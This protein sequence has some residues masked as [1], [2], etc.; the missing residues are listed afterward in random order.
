M[1]HT[2]SILC[3]S[4]F[5]MAQDPAARTAEALLRCDAAAAAAAAGSADAPALR[6]RLQAALVAP[7][8]RPAA[9][10]AV[11]AQFPDSD[12]ADAAIL[13]G[14][15]AV[16][17][18]RDRG[19][20][21]PELMAWLRQEDAEQWSWYDP[22]HEEDS[23]QLAPLV[24]G[25][26]RAL[27]ARTARAGDNAT[28]QRARALLQRCRLS[29]FGFVPARVLPQA[30]WAL[31][32]L[33]EALQLRAWRR[34]PGLGDWGEA[35]PVRPA[36]VQLQL[37]PTQTSMPGLGAGDWLL[38]LAASESPWRALRTVEV[39]DLDVVALCDGSTLALGAWQQGEPVR[40]CNWQ[41]R[42]GARAMGTGVLGDGAGVCFPTP[43]VDKAPCELLAQVAGSSAWVQ[44][45]DGARWNKWQ[46]ADEG[47]EDSYE[48]HLMLDRS[49]YRPGQ[50]LQGRV[51]VRR[52]HFEGKG[53]DLVVSTGPA[54]DMPITV[55]PFA[56]EEVPP[57]MGRTD[58]H[59]VCAFELL[60]P[61][62]GIGLGTAAFAI[63]V[64][65][66]QVTYDYDACTIANYRR[67]AL[68]VDVTG[69]EEVEQGAGDPQF[70]VQVR[71]ASGAP[72]ADVPVEVVAGLG[73]WD[74]YPSGEYRENGDGS[75]SITV[76]APWRDPE[77]G[78]ELHALR[79]DRD[80]KVVV[81]VK[82][83]NLT[84]NW[85]HLHIGVE[86][87]DGR[88]EQFLR[89]LY[90][91][92][93]APPA[94]VEPERPRL[95]VAGPEL[96][97]VGQA[98][99]VQVSGEAGAHVLFVAGRGHGARTQ[100]LQLDGKG[101]AFVEVTPTRAEWPWLDL[102]VATLHDWYPTRVPMQL[103]AAM[104]P[105]VELPA[106]VRPGEL[107]ACR[108]AT[109]APGTIVTVAVVDER[110]FAMVPD[111]TPEPN[112]ALRPRAPWP[113][114]THL[115]SGFA[116]TPKELLG[117]MLEHGRV[118]PAG[119]RNSLDPPA[120]GFAA[121]GSAGPPG[122]DEVREDFR[123]TAAFATVIAGA[124]G[125]ATV[126][127][128]L[129]DD[130]TTW[131]VRIVGVAPDGTSF[132]LRRDM[133]TRLPLAAEP[134]LPRVLRVGDQVA[135]PVAI[136]RAAVSV[137][138]GVSVQLTAASD[139]MGLAVAPAT[140]PCTVAPGSAGQAQ[141]TLQAVAA[142]EAKLSLGV[143]LGELRD[144]SRRAIVVQP[145][146][147]GRAMTAA[148]M[149]QAKV[150]VPTP[151]GVDPARELEVT[152]LG[153]SA[154][155]WRAIAD[156]LEAYPYGCAE[157]TLSRLLPYFA[158]VRGRKAHGRPL[159]QQDPAFERRLDQGM[160]RLRG[161]QHGRGGGFAFW[162]HGEVDLGITVLVLHGLCCV[163][164]GGLDPAQFGLVADVTAAP[165]AAAL[166]RLR[167]RHGVLADAG[168]AMA[169]ELLAACLRLQPDCAAA[170]EA[171]QAGIDGGSPLSPGLLAR[172]GLALLA[173]GD[174]RRAQLCR[175]RSRDAGMTNTT[176]RLAPDS[177]PGDDPLAVT[178]QQLELAS[179]LHGD[180]ESLAKEAG[181]V[182][183][184]SLRDGGSTFAMGCALSALALALPVE[185]ASVDTSF[186]ATVHSGAIE[187]AVTLDAEHGFTARMRVP[188]AAVCSATGPDDRQLLLVV[189]GER[190]ERASDHASWR[191]PLAV[192]R[193]L[194]RRD[195]DAT[196]EQRKRGE[197]LRP[198]AADE[199]HRNELLWL[200]VRVHSPVPAR[201]VVVDC[202]LP[203]GFELPIEPAFVERFDDRV[204]FTVDRLTGDASWAVPVLA[205]IT[206]TMVWPPAT[207]APMY[208]TGCEG[209]TA[210]AVL[211]VRAQVAAPA[212][213]STAILFAVPPPPK[214]VV[215]ETV[216]ERADAASDVVRDACQADDPAAHR[217]AVD[218]AFAALSQ[219]ARPADGED[220]LGVLDSL[221]CDLREDQEALTGAP[222]AEPIDGW[223]H[224]AATLQR[225][226]VWDV[227]ADL[228]D[229][230]ARQSGRDVVRPEPPDAAAPSDATA[231]QQAIADVIEAAS[232]AAADWPEAEARE[233]AQ[234]A[235]AHQ[236][237]ARGMLWP[238]ALLDGIQA[239][240]TTAALR[241]ELLLA[242]GATQD[243]W[244]HC[245]LE[246]MP[247]S[248]VAE[249]PPTLLAHQQDEVWSDVVVEALLGSAS[250]RVE[251]RRC[252]QQKETLYDQSGTLVS[253][254]PDELWAAVPLA[255]YAEFPWGNLDDDDDD[256]AAL[257]ATCQRHLA[258]S[259]IAT[260]ALQQE[261]ADDA[262]LDW[263]LFLAQVLRL[264][265][266]RDLG[267]VKIDDEPP[268]VWWARALAAAA[269]DVA[270]AAQFAAEARHS[271]VVRAA[272]GRRGV[273]T[274][275]RLVMPQ[276]AAHGSVA[277]LLPVAGYLNE[278]ECRAVYARL[279][280][281][282]VRALLAG[283]EDDLSLL[284]RAHDTDD[285]AALW[286][287]GVRCGEL[288]WVIDALA[289]TGAGLQ[290]LKAKLDGGL[291]GGLDGRDADRAREAYAEAMG[292]DAETLK[293]R[294]DAP[295]L[296]LLR[297][298]ARDGLAGAA[299]EDQR[300]QLDELR[301]LRGVR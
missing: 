155:A 89:R 165:F 204:A 48:A 240:A 51:L 119:Y 71:W 1:L 224:R 140:Q 243:R 195:P 63:E 300:R 271:P 209:G 15:A 228:R 248:D 283:T 227:I 138:G 191:A 122:V 272:Y 301:L 44:P 112:A 159:P 242:A 259:P 47:R 282:S 265:G 277:Q 278:I 201:Y 149:G 147:V 144:R 251:L 223:T 260:D 285:A 54:A 192:E 234:A 72:A 108:V 115:A 193:D 286:N 284:Q 175:D 299:T 157:Q 169:M 117:A 106:Q 141:V 111:T 104:T 55:K 200:R 181:V 42:S 118:P 275:L 134:L 258:Q 130:L 124:D 133:V 298:V 8:Q 255:A 177:F 22:T 3:L 139:A 11:A 39:S 179:L 137:A 289:V 214:P 170:R 188:F 73:G 67:P 129:P 16:M 257:R 83:R 38:E 244:R 12:E 262:D 4:A 135:V 291:D 296:P 225:R 76:T 27:D 35:S 167:G 110:I 237:A 194:C 158:A 101:E 93:P 125:V 7:L 79:T 279:D 178:A 252:L 164:D 91:K 61:T 274:L 78:H 156:R 113:D 163:R 154:A 183:Q 199:L 18:M 261:L 146:A 14:A 185:D 229:D 226:L 203:A 232:R 136:D 123:A 126:P 166:A 29:R 98:C 250:G 239:P 267:A 205:T 217:A 13:A 85:A 245:F 213:A 270:A 128:T 219:L 88:R 95:D 150:Q 46:S 197:D 24:E 30:E 9:M 77:T 43:L 148:A 171:V 184:Q 32:R 121:P 105:Q 57:V 60:V 37:T 293:P 233:A 196:E 207:A 172:A 216:Y 10:L 131:R 198:I 266:V 52:S 127:F 23:L 80:G 82:L 238:N 68:L 69:P 97:T 109:G 187:R 218:A 230:L 114:W 75:R 31:P 5:V 28:L 152:V 295:L 86:G 256:D 253:R 222:P 264:R 220:V 56:R 269:D 174:A 241:T 33:G 202:P 281:A 151:D 2:L 162:P 107:V 221:L 74:R 249:V 41:L 62:E 292:F 6:A 92:P 59:G 212:D 40:G 280:A 34:Q 182:L 36:D 161:L 287:Y 211:T 276:L 173:A 87:P 99:R 294:A 288:P 145:D 168:D 180:A 246:L 297:A 45:L 189:R 143:E 235:L 84:S 58:A 26:L 254:L 160:A 263:R 208:A 206:G 64:D 100:Q 90:V 19:T 231:H 20:A 94:A 116:R 17:A 21:V 186:A 103:H 176:G 50:L 96:A 120:P 268:L 153:S 53:R 236:L 65:G 81:S 132:Q 102:A 247:R 290:F 66:H 210:G 70:V 215:E 25:L 273:S 190:S 142:G 49:L